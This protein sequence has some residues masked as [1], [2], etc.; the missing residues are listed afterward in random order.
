MTIQHRTERHRGACD[1]LKA[2]IIADQE[3]RRSG[4]ATAIPAGARKQP[5]AMVR[6]TIREEYVR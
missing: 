3:R 4:A 2:R 1:Q 5:R 6:Q